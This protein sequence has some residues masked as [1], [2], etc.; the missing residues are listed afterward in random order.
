MLTTQGETSEKSVLER[1]SLARGTAEPVEPTEAPEQEPVEEEVDEQPEEEQQEAETET[2]EAETE[3]EEQPDTQEEAEELYIDLDGEEIALS[4]IKSWKDGNLRQSDYTKKTTELA[5][6]RKAFE[7]EKAKVE[8]LQSELA[9]K[10]ASLD[11]IIAESTLSAEQLQELKEDDPEGYIAYQEKMQKR[12]ELINSTKG[13]AVDKQ[14]VS[15]KLV[16]ANPDWLD[17][18]KPTEKFT[19]DMELVKSYTNEIGYSAQEL[20]GIEQN[21]DTH[22]WLTLLDAARGRK[23]IKELAALKGSAETKRNRKA[24]L[25]TKP[26]GKGP[27]NIDRQIE[28][29]RAK[30]KASG[31]ENDAFAYRKLLKQKKG[32]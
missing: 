13:P 32:N 6:Q 14:K 21:G 22:H 17:G 1:I 10:S 7:A 16:E 28:Q 2:E 5:E 25:V 3:E 4:E 23:A 19:Q 8:A 11:A 24:P 26:K 29:A 27:S 20:A 12:K 15:D 9:T 18:G 30:F 31:H